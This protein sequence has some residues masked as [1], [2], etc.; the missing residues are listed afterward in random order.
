MV[1]KSPKVM[2]AVDWEPNQSESTN[3]DS[4]PLTEQADK[5]EVVKSIDSTTVTFFRQLFRHNGSSETIILCSC[6]PSRLWITFIR[7]DPYVESDAR[8]VHA[9]GLFLMKQRATFILLNLLSQQYLCLKY[10]LSYCSSDRSTPNGAPL[11]HI[12]RPHLHISV[13]QTG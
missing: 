6:S 5:I 4:I 8:R 1:I 12:R 2:K 11:P 7:H 3:G 13:I 9:G 10:Q